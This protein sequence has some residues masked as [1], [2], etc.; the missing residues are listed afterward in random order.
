MSEVLK[1]ARSPLHVTSATL[2]FKLKPES[3]HHMR[4]H[5]LA[6]FEECNWKC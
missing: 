3:L 1:V 2:H 6:A 5:R 4:P